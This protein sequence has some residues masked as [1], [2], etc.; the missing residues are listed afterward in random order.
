MFFRFNK[1]DYSLEKISEIK[2][3]NQDKAEQDENSNFINYIDST[4]DLKVTIIIL[5]WLFL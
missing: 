4:E 1:N 3:E 5:L 2:I